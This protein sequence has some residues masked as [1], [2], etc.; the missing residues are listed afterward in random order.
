MSWKIF[1]KIHCFIVTNDCF[2]FFYLVIMQWYNSIITKFVKRKR[3]DFSKRG[4]AMIDDTL[5]E[6]LHASVYTVVTGKLTALLFIILESNC[7]I[8]NEED[9]SASAKKGHKVPANIRKTPIFEQ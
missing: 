9:K 2:I 1:T 7:T 3:V 5:L 8:Q 4:Y 6:L